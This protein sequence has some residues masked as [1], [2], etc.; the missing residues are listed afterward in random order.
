MNINDLKLINTPF[1]GCT[2]CGGKLVE[3]RGR[4]PKD[5]KREVCPTCLADRL[6]DINEI[7]SRYYGI[8]CQEKK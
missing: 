6:D 5:T 3:I 4:H 1:T 7:S 2:V 8:S